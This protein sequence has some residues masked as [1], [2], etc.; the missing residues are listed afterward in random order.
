MS[1]LPQHVSIIMDGNGRWAKSRGLDRIHGHREGIKSVREATEFAVENKIKYLSL[2]AFSEENWNRPQDEVYGLMGLMI[3]AIASE[4][5]TL[6]QNN[7]RFRVLGDMSKLPEELLVKIRQ[8]ESITSGNTA[9]T[10]IIFLSYGGRWDILQA[11]AKYAEMHFAARERGEIP[12]ELTQD[13][14]SSLLSTAGIPDPD[15]LIRTS[16]E[17]RVSNFLLWQSAYSE[18]YFPEILWPDF[19]KNDFQKALD[20]YAHRERRFGKTGEQINN[21]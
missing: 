5:A 6:M 14:F 16:G 13:M 21:L 7:V 15:L 19:R 20:L 11:A 2:F 12:A 18:F 1:R 8:T 9:L 17:E 4:T 3:D 10:M